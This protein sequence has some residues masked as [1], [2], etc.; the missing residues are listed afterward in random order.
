MCEKCDAKLLA[1]AQAALTLAQAAKVLYDINDQDG[2]RTLAKASA[3]LFEEPKTSG[4]TD[5]A[6]VSNEDDELSAQLPAGMQIKDGVVYLDGVAIGRAVFI[7]RP[8]TH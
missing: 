7:K 4:E 3:S 1:G 8:T 5:T 6:S 2:S